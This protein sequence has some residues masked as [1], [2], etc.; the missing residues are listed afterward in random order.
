MFDPFAPSPTIFTIAPE[1][2]TECHGLPPSS[3]E[4][5]AESEIQL[6]RGITPDTD[7]SKRS[8]AGPYRLAHEEGRGA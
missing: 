1:P 7:V 8:T 3:Q 2:A 4:H 5:A 6:P